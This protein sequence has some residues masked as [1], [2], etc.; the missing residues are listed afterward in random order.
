MS[1]NT[2]PKLVSVGFIARH[3]TIP[4]TFAG[5]GCRAKLYAGPGLACMGTRAAYVPDSGND[6]AWEILEVFVKEAE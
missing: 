2:S 4:N 1:E 3:R 6:S 5:H